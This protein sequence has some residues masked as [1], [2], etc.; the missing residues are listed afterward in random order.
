M[1]TE[2]PDHPYQLIFDALP[3]GVILFDAVTGRVTEANPAAAALYGYTREAFIGLHPTAYLPAADAARLAEWAAAVQA[4]ETVAATAIHRRLSGPPMVIEMHG[5]G[6][7]FRGH[8]CLLAVVR[9]ISARVK[10][11]L[12]EQAERNGRVQALATLEERRRLAQ[13]LHDAVNQSLFSA[14]LIAEVLPRLLAQHPDEVLASL[15]DLR[16]LTRGALAEMRG[17]LVEL[18][19]LDLTDSDLGDL[20]RLLGDA[21]TGRTG[22]PVDLTVSGS[23]P[24]PTGV[25]VAFYRLCQEALNNT[26]KHARAGRVAIDLRYGPEA[27]EMGVRDDGRGFDPEH[28]PAGHYGLSMMREWAAAANLALAITS[29]PGEGTEIAVRWPNTPEQTPR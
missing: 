25:Q 9:D 16:R 11:G 18:Q 3:D 12:N 19:P 5:T 13:N 28:S 23:G 20:L 8:P 29:R 27:A 15:E 26:A 24:L 17:L 14:S 22:I 7:T 21:Y 6:C 10:A 2:S 1:P 4:G